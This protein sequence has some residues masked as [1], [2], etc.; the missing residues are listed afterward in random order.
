MANVQHVAILSLGSNTDSQQHMAQA[1]ELLT[2]CFRPIRFSSSL[3]TEPIGIQSPPFLN[4]VAVGLTS[5]EASEVNALLKDIE[6]ACGNTKQ[7]RQQ[8]KILIDI[9][10]LWHGHTPYHAAD[11]QRSYIQTLL[12]EMG[13]PGSPD[14]ESIGQFVNNIL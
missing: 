6:S 10:L 3:R 8:G 12:G 5:L 7:L 1:K 11:W 13:I 2:K 9:D 4:A 14:A